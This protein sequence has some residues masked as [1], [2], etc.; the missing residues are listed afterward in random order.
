MVLIV[1]GLSGIFKPHT[2]TKAI[3]K[4]KLSL[5]NILLPLVHSAALLSAQ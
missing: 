1:L 3:A 5:E 2:A 4:L